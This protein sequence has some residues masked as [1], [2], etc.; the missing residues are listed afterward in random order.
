ML[1]CCNANQLVSSYT[2]TCKLIHF[3]LLM[4]T[5]QTICLMAEAGTGV[6]GVE[7][8]RSWREKENWKDNN[9]AVLVLLGAAWCCCVTLG[10]VYDQNF[11]SS[12]NLI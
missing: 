7:F 11:V 10:A 5:S 3:V 12:Q 1:F 9:L 6:S 4:T 2:S 8:A